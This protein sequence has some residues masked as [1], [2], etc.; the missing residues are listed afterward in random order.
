MFARKKAEI[1]WK[2]V[3]GAFT[4]QRR[5]HLVKGSDGLD[6]C[7]ITGCEHPGFSSQRGCRKHV[8]IKY[9]W[10]YYFDEKPNVS[11]DTLVTSQSAL[12]GI[13]EKGSKTIPSCSTDNDFARSFSQWLQSSCGGGKSRKQSDISVTRAL[14]LSSFAATRDKWCIGQSGRIAYVGSI[15]DLLDFR[16]FNRP[17]ASV[18]QN[19]A[20][21]EVYVKR[22]R[23][24]L[25]KDMRSNW[26]TELDVETLE[27]RRSWATLSEVQ[28][29]IPFHMERYESVLENCM[30]HPASVR[31]GDVTFATRF[32]AAYLFLKVKGCRPMTYQHLTLRMFESARRNEGMVDQKIFKTA[33]R[34]GFDSVY[35]DVSSIE[36]LEKYITY[37]RPL[38]TPTCEYVLVNRNG[39]QFQKLTDLLS[40]LVFEAIGKYI[41]PTRYR[42]IIETESSQ[43]LLPNEQKWISEDQKH[44][45]N[46][47]R[48]HYQKKRSREVAIRGRWCMQKL[49]DESKNMESDH[50]KID[51]SSRGQDDVRKDSPTKPMETV[52]RRSGVRF[53]IEEDKYIRVGIEKFGL[54][55][56]KILRHPEFHFNPCRVANTLRKRAEVLKLV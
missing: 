17:P 7:P 19:F 24:C 18:L 31:P 36:L 47:A 56:S 42:Q 27:S 25:A 9:G 46:V 11:I 51:Q 39:N 49:V 26:T 32:V 16:K 37:I 55:W 6:H 15:S 2:L 38:L 43:V 35:L 21:T 44:S 40:V 3:D 28:S 53:T 45:S 50:E 14:S 5:L 10:Y 52:P 23:K 12:N 1:D 22:A 33:K 54:R 29:V 20:V 13:D 30:T 48:V 34:Y 4:K 41:H 8:K